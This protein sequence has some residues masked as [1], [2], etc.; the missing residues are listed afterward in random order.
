[1]F[2]CVLFSP[3][4]QLAMERLNIFWDIHKDKSELQAVEH[5]SEIVV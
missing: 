5:Y 3:R 1:M 2:F 4:P